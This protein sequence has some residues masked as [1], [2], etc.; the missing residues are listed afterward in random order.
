MKK[1]LDPTCGRLDD[2]IGQCGAPGLC[3]HRKGSPTPPADVD[4]S[5][6][7]VILSA[8]DVR[9]VVSVAQLISGRPL[10]VS[11]FGEIGDRSQ[12]RAYVPSNAKKP[13][14][15]STPPATA[16]VNNGGDQG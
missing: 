14:K 8:G 12:V 1:C 4:T 5:G 11:G 15:A 2:E 13:A 3:P 16:G 10:Q 9:R 6:R 7:D